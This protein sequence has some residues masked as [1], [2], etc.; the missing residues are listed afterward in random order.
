MK[1]A[2]IGASHKQHRYSYMAMKML[3]EYGHQIFLVH[4]KLAEIEGQ[5]VVSKVNQID[6]KIDTM[7]FYVNKSIS[8][9]M[10]EQIEKVL[11]K[12]AIFNPGAENPEL[13]EKL[14]TKGV[15]CIDACTLVLLRTEQFE[16]A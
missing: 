10:W 14:E 12:R 3:Q 7:T 16:T 5:K 2:I 11:P 15:H 4:P 6:D 13:A 9:S 1:V 8:D